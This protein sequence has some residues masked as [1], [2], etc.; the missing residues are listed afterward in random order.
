MSLNSPI[1]RV[2]AWALFALLLLAGC[3]KADPLV[4]RWKTTTAEGTESIL[5]FKS[6]GTFEGL[7]GGEK[8]VGK[9]VFRRESEPNQL[10]LNFE[11]RKV[12]TI[13]KLVNDQLLIEPRADG[14]ALPSKFSDEAQRYLRQ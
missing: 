1:Y 2:A 5:S 8:L 9:W 11:A 3:N 4:G 10:E 12:V 13:A 7:T 6:D 14:A